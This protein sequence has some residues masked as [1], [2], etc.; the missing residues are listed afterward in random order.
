[1]EE[2]VPKETSQQSFLSPRWELVHHCL[3]HIR[4]GECQLKEW[5]YGLY[6]F[7]FINL[8]LIEGQ[9]LYRTLLFSVKPQH[10][11]AIGIH[12]SPPF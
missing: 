6:L 11:S 5:G 2:G 12:I 8:F 9:L 7:F 3:G 4:Q 1:M 10:D